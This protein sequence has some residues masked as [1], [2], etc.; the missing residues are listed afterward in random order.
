MFLAKHPRISHFCLYDVCHAVS[1]VFEDFTN[2]SV[3]YDSPT[4][5]GVRLTEDRPFLEVNINGESYL[6]D[7][8]LKRMYK[9]NFF[10]KNA[11]KKSQKI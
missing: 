10:V 6:I 8:L 2:I 1:T 11:Q 9:K 3:I 7:F 5:K 4:R